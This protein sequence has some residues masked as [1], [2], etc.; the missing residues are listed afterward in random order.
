[1]YISHIS[2]VGH[3]NFFTGAKHPWTGRWDPDAEDQQFP[4]HR[5]QRWEAQ[6][7][8]CLQEPLQVHEEQG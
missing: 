5:Q 3:Q 2:H 4:E 8:W 6:A 7:E 1:M